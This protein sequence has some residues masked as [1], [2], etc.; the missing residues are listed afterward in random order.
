MKKL[1]AKTLIIVALAS[2]ILTM[3]STYLWATLAAPVSTVF[4]VLVFVFAISSVVCL[5]TAVD[6]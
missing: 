5:N 4:S 3:L 1:S 6:R 2:L